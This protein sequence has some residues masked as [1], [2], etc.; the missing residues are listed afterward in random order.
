M[1]ETVPLVQVESTVVAAEAD[2]VAPLE[3]GQVVAAMVLV[4]LMAQEAVDSIL[5]VVQIAVGVPLTIMV[6]LLSMVEMVV[7]PRVEMVVLKGAL[8]VVLESVIEPAE[9]VVT[10]VVVEMVALG[11]AEVVVLTTAEPTK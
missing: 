7:L 11:L 8:A 5:M 3:M 1:L 6:N 2:K 10:P 9:V 4:A